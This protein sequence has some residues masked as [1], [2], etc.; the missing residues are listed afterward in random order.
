MQ[1]IV[2]AVVYVPIQIKSYLLVMGHVYVNHNTIVY[3]TIHVQP[4]HKNVIYVQIIQ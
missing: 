2:I 1:H 3:Q 4:V